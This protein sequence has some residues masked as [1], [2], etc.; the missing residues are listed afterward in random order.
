MHI[1]EQSFSS[2]VQISRG[3]SILP[4]SLRIS[5][6][7]ERG[8]PEQ[9]ECDGVVRDI[10]CGLFTEFVTSCT[11]WV[12]RS[13]SCHWPHH[14]EK[15]WEA[16]VHVMLYGLKVGYFTI[17]IS[18]MFLISLLLSKDEVTHDMLLESFKWYVSHRDEVCI[19]SMLT[20]Y[21][22]ESEEELIDVLVSYK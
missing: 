13:C 19:T 20:Q 11:N 1:L 2:D 22:P 15:N 6:I 16:V 14:E 4:F 9:G 7:D 10:I 3:K 18:P 5:V 8:K 21:D 17:C 12:H